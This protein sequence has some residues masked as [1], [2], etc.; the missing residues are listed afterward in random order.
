MLCTRQES[1]AEYQIPQNQV[2]LQVESQVFLSFLSIILTR[3]TILYIKIEKKWKI[4]N[5]FYV[6]LPEY[7]IIKKR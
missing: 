4:Y 3:Q 7:N 2:E 1:L 5:V 6:S